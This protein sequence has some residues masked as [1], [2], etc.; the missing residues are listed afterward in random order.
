MHTWR[1][2]KAAPSDTSMMLSPSFSWTRPER[3][4]SSLPSM[5][6]EKSDRDACLC[7]SGAFCPTVAWDT[8]EM[9]NAVNHG[10]KC[11]NKSVVHLFTR[12]N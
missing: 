4:T 1:N 10:I 2:E 12:F 8:N 11:W 7:L 9:K 5:P 6:S 3:L